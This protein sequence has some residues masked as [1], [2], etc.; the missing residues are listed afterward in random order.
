[1]FEVQNVTIENLRFAPMST[2][3]AL[4]RDVLANLE[5]VRVEHYAQGEEKFIENREA[6]Y[7]SKRLTP[8]D[9]VTNSLA[10]KFY[11]DHGVEEICEGLD[12]RTSTAGEQVVISDY[13]IRREIGE[14]LLE[15]PRLR[16]DLYLV[17]GTKKYRLCFDCKACQMKMIDEK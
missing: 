16:G 17:R 1:M 10:R 6:R 13:C 14:C 8:Q 5:D 3:G 15:K 7:P 4:R 9:N 11:S 2:V 12:C